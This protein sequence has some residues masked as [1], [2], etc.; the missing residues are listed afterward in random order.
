VSDLAEMGFQE[1]P[2][3]AAVLEHEGSLKDAVRA[4]VAGERQQ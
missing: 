2:A 4:L 3:R 1:E